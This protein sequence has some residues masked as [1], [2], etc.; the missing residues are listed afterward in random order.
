MHMYIYIHVHIFSTYV[1]IAA[2]RK[3][4]P[5]LTSV[6]VT[7][8]VFPPSTVRIYTAGNKKLDIYVLIYVWVIIP[9]YFCYYSYYCYH[10]HYDYELL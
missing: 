8:L 3:Y 9:Y 7:G 2:K 1:S 4:L 6:L 10:Y 5:S